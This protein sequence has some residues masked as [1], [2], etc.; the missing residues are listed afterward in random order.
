MSRLRGVFGGTFDPVH[1]GHLRPAL[2]VMLQSGL[3]EV[4]F[5]PNRSPPHRN[6]PFLDDQLRAELVALAIAQTPGFVMDGR[7][8]HRS[9]PSYMVDTLESLKSEF[10]EDTLCLM[11][12]MDAFNGL[13]QWHRWQAIPELCHLIVTT[14]PGAERVGAELTGFAEQSELLARMSKDPA[15]LRSRSAGQ[16]LLQ[17]VTQLDISASS[18]R[19]SLL[20][21][22]SIQYLLPEVLR[23]KLEHAYA[24][25][26]R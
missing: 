18:I 7:E 8:L 16:I 12:G 5:I 19:Q 11:M 24:R 20:R 2:D 9:G 25:Y 10:P 4:R 21:G 6:A 13:T 3:D 22:Q 23:E 26:N 17:S 14:R 1:Y 15:C